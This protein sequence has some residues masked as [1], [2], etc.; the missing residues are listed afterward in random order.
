MTTEQ[1]LTDD[2]QHDTSTDDVG[3]DGISMNPEAF[4]SDDEDGGVFPDDEE[5]VADDGGLVH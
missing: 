5:S 1:Y 2:A 3:G 4:D